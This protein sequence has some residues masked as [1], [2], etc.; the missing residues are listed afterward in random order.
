M[1]SGYFNN[2]I[3]LVGGYSTGNITPAFLQVWE[4]DPVLNTFVT[5]TPIPA[6]VGFGGAGSGVING[7]LY[8][9]GGRDANNTVINTTW[10]YN[11]ATD[12]WTQR[13]NMPSADNVP[14]SAVVGG[15]L[16]VFGGGNPFV[17]SG[18]APK[19]GDKKVLAPDTTNMLQIYN[20][21]TDTWTSGPNLLQTLSFP[22]GTHVGGTAVAVGGYTGSSTTNQ[23]EINVTSGG[24]ATP[25][26]TPT[27]TATAP[28]ATPTATA[29]A[30]ATHTPTATPT[31]TA[32]QPPPSPTPTATATQPPPSPTPTTT[33][34][35]TPTPRPPPP[36]RPPGGR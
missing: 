32:T 16:W 11:I 31:A 33:P 27:A 29:T 8:V 10:D 14:G 1:A 7:H 30:T 34:R 36:P 5:K 26:A 9:A 20:P 18:A 23:V 4:Y 19:A 24:C 3:Y 17:G 12:T 28:S 13:A 15:K 35:H 25:T 22:A 21:G 2:K 6:A